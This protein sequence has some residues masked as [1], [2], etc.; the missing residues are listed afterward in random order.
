MFTDRAIKHARLFISTIVIYKIFSVAAFGQETDSNGAIDTSDQTVTQTTG[1]GSE[2]HNPPFRFWVSA[3]PTI[4]TGAER[5]FGARVALGG[6]MYLDDSH[7]YFLT[8]QVNKPFTGERL[9]GQYAG[10]VHRT[11]LLPG[12]G[13]YFIPEKLYGRFNLGLGYL[14]S[15]NSDI[16]AKLKPTYAFGL[17]YRQA[18]NKNWDWG[19]EAS[20]EYTGQAKKSIA[21]LYDDLSCALGDCDAAGTIPRANIWSLNVFLGYSL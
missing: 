4:L 6:D 3:G 19:L 7:R 12:L 16:L 17:G 15:S 9:S 1:G 11:Y 10:H 5:Y 2:S 13:M 18:I 20:F 14:T 8:F 21:F